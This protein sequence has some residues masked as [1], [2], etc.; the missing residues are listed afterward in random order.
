MA[1][2][3]CHIPPDGV[4]AAATG[5]TVSTEI[6]GLNLPTNLE[7][8]P[9]GRVFVAEKQG[10]VVAYDG[11]ADTTPTVTAD[12][13][14][15]IHNFE[16][17][18]LLGLEVDPAFPTRP[19]LYV[20]YTLDRND[21][22][23]DACPSPPGTFDDGCVV[24]ARLARL[25]VDA[26]S[27]MVGAEHVLLEDM[28]CA[29]FPSHTVGDLEF[30]PDGALLVSAG[31]G[32]DYNS[33]D[34]GQNGGDAGS[35]TP[36]NPCGD[37]PGGLGEALTAPTARGGALRA[38]TLTGVGTTHTYDGSIL[39]VD[40]D[41]GAALPD[42]PLVGG[43]DPIDDRVIAHGLRNPYRMASRPGTGELWVG[44]VGWGTWEEV[45]RITSPTDPVVENFG[46]PCYESNEQQST[47]L[48]VGLDACTGLYDGTLS[49]SVTSPYY[50]YPHGAVPDSDHCGT[51]MGASVTGLSFYDG[52]GS[53]DDY[54]A[55]YDGALFFGDYARRCIWAMLP[56]T[57]G[58]PDPT[59]VRTMVVG[60]NVV[61]LETGPGGDIYWVD[62]IEGSIG[63]LSYVGASIPPQASLT[64][65]PDN[66]PL[67]LA[68][69]LDG[70]HSVAGAGVSG[71]LTYAWDLDGDGA[72]DDGTGATTSHTYSVAGDV[73][74][75]LRV[76]NSNGLSD[77][78]STVVH[79]G[80]SRPVPVISSPTAGALWDADQVLDLSGTATDAEDGAVAASTYTWQ[81]NLHHCSSATDCHVHPLQTISGQ[82]STS[83]V[84]PN[85]EYPA[86]LMLT[87]TVTDS[88]GLSGSAS[89]RLDPR[90]IDVQ[91][92]TA[93]SGLLL[94][95]G[96]RTQA[97]PFT[98]R[99]IAGSHLTV[100]A[101][102]PQT[103]G[104]TPYGFS[105]W[106]DGGARV[107]DI[108]LTQPAT[109]TASYVPSGSGPGGSGVVYVSD[110]PWMAESNGFGPAERDLSNGADAAADGTTLALRGE[111]FVKGIGAHAVGS[112]TVDV[113]AGCTGFSALVGVDD[114]VG[115]N[116][117]V[118]F[119]V[120][121]GGSSLVTTPVLTSASTAYPVSV[122]VTG[123]AQLTLSVGNGGDNSH[124]D[125]ADW[126][127]ARF[128]CGS[129][130]PPASGAVFLS[131][132]PWT[133]VTNGFGPPERDTSNGAEPAVDGRRMALRGVTYPRGVGAHAASSLTVA[134]PAGCTEFSASVGVDDEV[135][136]NG[137]VV[138]TVS[139]AEGGVL[140]T[141][142]TLTSSS[143]AHALSVDVTGVSSLVLAVGNAGDD[144]YWD[145]ADWADAHFV[146]SPPPPGGFSP[147]ISAPT[148]DRTHSVVA[149]DLDA[150]G[151]LDLVAAAAGA[152][153]AVVL[154]RTG[155]GPSG[156]APAASYPT[157]AGT[158]PKHVEVG[159]LTGDGVLDLV[160]A[161]QDSTTGQD[162]TVFPGLGDG[163]F[164]AAVT[165]GAC[166][167]PHQTA[168]GDLDGDTDLDVMVACWGGSVV[169]VLRN[170]GGGVLGAPVSFPAADAPHS[171]VLRDLDG[172][173]DLDAAVAAFGDNRL[174]VLLNDGM[175][176]FGPPSL[177]WSGLGPHNVVSGDVDA[178]GDADLVVTAQ[179]D[180]AVG[181]IR[182][183][184]D[185]TFADAEFYGVGLAPKATAVGDLDGDGDLDLVTANTHG[186]YP[187]G[188]TP[189]S[190]T[191]LLG[192]G[193]GTFT[194]GYTLPND[195]TPFNL[196]IAD[197]DA[198]GKTDLAT[199]NWHSSDVK[200]HYHP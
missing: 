47:Y 72:Y 27:H 60:A 52:S 178:D 88:T 73:T 111:T 32:A 185:G 71:G 162:V 104:G 76:T 141:T 87:L 39:R 44:D 194:P 188:S 124:W 84:A 187:N 112:L 171:L 161:N 19:Y 200:I 143:A 119:A 35:P 43:D 136:A 26:A 12:L 193:T 34:F 94:G 59:T 149:R 28:W 77:V 55:A 123:L 50:A 56:G 64:V 169:S 36:A 82:P 78:A 156:Y 157:G 90:T 109:Y 191:V 137:S 114:E 107:H 199:A 85:H 80:N 196:T 164:G 96:S 74:V 173:S 25:T 57:S 81:V 138:F 131:D 42:N 174:A 134:V 153:A 117:S 48:T 9:D 3:A 168:L 95:V 61:D 172:D 31:D 54:P 145:H 110:L 129:P 51:D 6:T 63:R 192:T 120:S 91:F 132:L 121:S 163:T 10:T 37:P 58:V 116:G 67:P 128:I 135:G 127:A 183:N 186:N 130:P 101:L 14:G 79:A 99:V 182:S 179:N 125:H 11:L 2:P 24:D 13:T 142:P 190:L 159:D 148:G 105:S 198:N 92:A 53:G 151:D 20:F 102:T 22:W 146:C 68:V 70:T 65:T 41:T 49:S 165:Y 66:G 75:G 158:F 8:A 46:W 93:P 62:I 89:L 86:Y 167:R 170:G 197:L 195:L 16:D 154:L 166:S 113:P 18:G 40:P 189:T 33:V 38:Q 176:T 144:N 97:T 4:H 1:V 152:D 126:A 7:F 106:S 181:V 108:T 177:L 83:I 140:A 69:Q 175:G 180:N 122:D 30:T 139:A 17:R 184:G 98:Q 147:P 5:F 45:N 21:S 160:T 133:A 29:Q 150:D 23:G 115:A 100:A 155:T 103:S 118:T 15:N